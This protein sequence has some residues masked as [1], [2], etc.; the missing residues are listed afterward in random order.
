[1]HLIS[2]LQHITTPCT[3]RNRSLNKI[4]TKRHK[5][6]ELIKPK[7]HEHLNFLIIFIFIS[8]SF[9]FNEYVTLKIC[10]FLAACFFILKQT[11][12]IE[13]FLSNDITSKISHEWLRNFISFFSYNLFYM[14]FCVS[15]G[16]LSC[17]APMWFWV[18]FTFYWA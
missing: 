10:C 8:I 17:H 7:A 4:E 9:S 1:M 14:C 5:Q 16:A 2:K 6:I 12:S 3:L 15:V 13:I 11:Q 18:L